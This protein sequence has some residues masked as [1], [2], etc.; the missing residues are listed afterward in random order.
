MSGSE[1]VE[2][3]VGLG[4]ARVRE[5]FQQA[6]EKAP[7]W[8]SSTSSTRSGRGAP[9]AMSGGLRRA[10]RARAD[11]QPAAGGDGRLRRLQGR[12]H[13]GGD[14]P[15]RRAGPCAGPAR[16]VRSA[17][18]RGPAGP[19]G[20]RGD[21]AGPRRGV[22]L[23]PSVDLRTIAARTPGFTGADLENV[24]NEA[25][26][27]AARREKN[28]VDGG[29]AR[30]SHRPGVVGSSEEP[31]DE[32]QGE[33]PRGVPR[34]GSRPRRAFASRVDP[35]HR[36]TIIPRGS[37]PSAS[38]DPAAGG[39]LPLHRA[40]AAGHA[41]VRDG[42]PGRRGAR[43]PRDLARGRRTTSR[44]PRRSRGPWWPSTA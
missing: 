7:A 10:R 26:L 14:E 37:V 4:A 16:A 8:C 35:V 19:E 41:G 44:R 25:A 36:V 5:L 29:G 39:P 40:R 43:V 20:P 21:P 11:A 28:S 1:F 13:H 18:R 42:W 24:V 9:G 15:P 12:D 6:K 17:G 31:G 30:G 32:R 3:F 38:H 27:L 33:D 2:M 23:D 34:D 22:A